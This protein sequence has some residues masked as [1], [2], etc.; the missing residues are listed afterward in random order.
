MSARRRRRGAE[1]G[2]ARRQR[3]AGGAV[4]D[5]RRRRSGQCGGGRRRGG[6][7]GERWAGVRGSR[8]VGGRPCARREARQR[9]AC[10]DCPLP[11]PS[12]GPRVRPQ[13][14]R[15]AEAQCQAQPC[16]DRSH[17]RIVRGQRAQQGHRKEAGAA[18]REAGAAGG[19]GGG[20]AAGGPRTVFK[21]RRVDGGEV[22]E[23]VP[24]LRARVD[25]GGADRVGARL[26]VPGA[27]ARGKR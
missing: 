13:S 9:A 16:P 22:G 3:A 19:A 20:A 15:R 2:V 12:R 5:A 17:S 7:Q 8:R 1:A 26:Q 11:R 10:K 23:K 18:G 6:G 14:R 25:L 24:E 27:R 4:A 21:N